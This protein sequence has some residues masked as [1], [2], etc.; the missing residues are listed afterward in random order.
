MGQRL[1]AECIPFVNHAERFSPDAPDEAWLALPGAE[2]WPVITRDKNWRY[3]PNESAAF[4]N[5]RVLGFVFLNGNLSGRDTADLLVK[6]YPTICT[7]A[8]TAQRPAIHSIGSD[9]SVRPLALDKRL[10]D[11]G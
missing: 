8:A 4:S 6:A 5:A 10:R 2:G 9:G 1:A 3:K 11:R 7:I